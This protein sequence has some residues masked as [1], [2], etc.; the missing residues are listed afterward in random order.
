MS[1]VPPSLG[2]APARRGAPAA[3]MPTAAPASTSRR[4]NGAP[5]AGTTVPTSETNK[6]MILLLAAPLLEPCAKCRAGM[7]ACQ[8]YLPESSRK[9]RRCVRA[10]NGGYHP[11]LGDPGGVGQWRKRGNL[12]HSFIARVGGS[13][14]PTPDLHRG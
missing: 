11:Y 4:V 8:Q 5:P 12:Q 14:A 2:A 13:S 3:S 10:A 7:R 1:M 6:A 9:P